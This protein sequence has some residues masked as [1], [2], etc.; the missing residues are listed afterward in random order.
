LIVELKRHKGG[1]TGKLSELGRTRSTGK[2]LTP[3][4]ASRGGASNRR[5]P[6]RASRPR[7]KVWGRRIWGQAYSS[8]GG[9]QN[10]VGQR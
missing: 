4:I 3:S 7:G 10:K 2:E 5:S 9:R 1:Q 6:H 8:G